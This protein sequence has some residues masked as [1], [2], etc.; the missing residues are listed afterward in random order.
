MSRAARRFGAS[1]KHCIMMSSA[2]DIDGPRQGAVSTGKTGEVG[3]AANFGRLGAGE[4]VGT[5]T[6]YAARSPMPAE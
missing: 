2:Y 4:W 6:P 3:V 1:P 5:L